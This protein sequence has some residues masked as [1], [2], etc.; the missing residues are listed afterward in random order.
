MFN[1]KYKYV[2]SYLQLFKKE[3]IYIYINI[4]RKKIYIYIRVDPLFPT[5]GDFGIR[6]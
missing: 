3:Y 5:A 6:E 1:K 4:E 2:I